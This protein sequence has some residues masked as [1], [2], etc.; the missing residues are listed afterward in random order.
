MSSSPSS[1]SAEGGWYLICFGTLKT[2]LLPHASLEVQSLMPVQLMSCEEIC[3]PSIQQGM[4]KDLELVLPCLSLIYFILNS[5][6]E[7]CFFTRK[8]LQVGRFCSGWFWEQC[9]AVRGTDSKETCWRTPLRQ[10]CLCQSVLPPVK[11]QQYQ[12]LPSLGFPSQSSSKTGL[13]C[14]YPLPSPQSECRRT[15]RA[16]L[17]HV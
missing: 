12:V 10:I 5:V 17:Y 13:L 14:H 15:S 11:I 2:L 7:W 4:D 1:V 8:K 9:Y 3:A 16:A 6:S